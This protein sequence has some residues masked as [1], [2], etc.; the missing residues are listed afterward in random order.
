MRAIRILRATRW[1]TPQIGKP[2]KLNSETQ[3]WLASSNSVTQSRKM[4]NKPAKILPSVHPWEIHS[5]SLILVRIWYLGL[6]WLQELTVLPPINC[7]K[8]V[9]YPDIICRVDRFSWGWP[10]RHS[11][12]L[13][14]LW[15]TMLWN[16][17]MR[18]GSLCDYI[19][20]SAPCQYAPLRV[21]N[22]L[23]WLTITPL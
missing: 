13:S 19:V 16:I 12:V 2:V 8:L 7:S 15:L 14:S 22:H 11:E 1:L 5:H 9:G 23:I 21:N 3:Y 20:V 18:V 4:A 6:E 10:W 17:S